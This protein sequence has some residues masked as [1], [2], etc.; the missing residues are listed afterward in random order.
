MPRIANRTMGKTSLSCS[1]QFF[2]A[3]GDQ[4]GPAAVPPNLLRLG[5]GFSVAWQIHFH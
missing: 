1:G 2:Q 5:K 4:Q 3:L